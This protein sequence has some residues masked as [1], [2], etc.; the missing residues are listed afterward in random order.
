ALRNQFESERVLR[1]TPTCL[2]GLPKPASGLRLVLGHTLARKEHQAELK[3]G[4]RVTLLGR[5]AKPV[6]RLASVQGCP[7]GVVEHEAELVLRLRVALI[8]NGPGLVEE[9][10]GNGLL[11]SRGA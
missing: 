3:L 8:G 5:A 2:S 11:S 1:L 4:R 10:L 7:L 9:R 6:G